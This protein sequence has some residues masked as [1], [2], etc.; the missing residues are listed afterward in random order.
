MVL[1]HLPAQIFR[2]LIGIPN[3][4]HIALLF[5]VLNASTTYM[6]TAPRSAFVATIVLPEERTAVMGTLNVVKTAASSLGPAITGTLVDH[7]LFWVSFLLSGSLKAVYD[8][9][10]LVFFRHKER[11]RV[12]RDQNEDREQETQAE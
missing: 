8:V 3:N 5:Y 6:G 12:R 1:T 11:E 7:N 10:I 9:G 2:A 4:V